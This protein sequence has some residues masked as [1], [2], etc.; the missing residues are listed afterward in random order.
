M[1]KSRAWVLATQMGIQ[2]GTQAVVGPDS[3]PFCVEEAQVSERWMR[4]LTPEE[5]ADLKKVPEPQ[6]PAAA[7]E[8]AEALRARVAELEAGASIP[9]ADEMARLREENVRQDGALKSLKMQLGK[10]NKDKENLIGQL[11]QLRGQGAGS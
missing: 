4:R 11:K 5:V 6:Q 2:P 8:E 9:H 10:V 3:R 1:G 7:P